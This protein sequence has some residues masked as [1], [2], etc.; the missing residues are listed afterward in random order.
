MDDK[1]ILEI[2]DKAIERYGNDPFKF[3]G[4]RDGFVEGYKAAIASEANDIHNVIECSHRKCK[5]PTY[6][7][8]MCIKHFAISESNTSGR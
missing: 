7:F 6:E 8:G 4:Q 5:E 1:R 2:R 3:G